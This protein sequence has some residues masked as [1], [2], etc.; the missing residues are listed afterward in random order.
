MDFLCVGAKLLTWAAKLLFAVEVNTANG[1]D[2]DDNDDNDN[3]NDDEPKF[4]IFPPHGLLQLHGTS[5]KLV[6]FNSNI[7]RSFDHILELFTAAKNGR[8]DYVDCRISR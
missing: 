1:N 3:G 7:L 5:F 2:D 6:R 8:Y 4:K